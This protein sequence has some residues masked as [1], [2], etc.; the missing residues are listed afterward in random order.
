MERLI[1]FDIDGTLTRS[2]NGYIPFNEA[3]L[4]T[5]GIQG[6]IRT[7]VPDGNTDPRIVE[8]IFRKANIEMEIAQGNREQFALNLR[9]RYHQS[10]QQGTTIIRALPG[11][12]ELL[13]SLAAHGSYQQG[14]VTGNFEVTARIKLEA[15]GLSSY[16]GRG[17]FAGDSSHRPDLPAIAKARFELSLGKPIQSAQCIIVGDTPNDLEAARLNQ[18][19]CVL[20]GTGR[21]PLEE[22]LYWQP[23]ACLP[24]LSDTALVLK[25]I[26]NL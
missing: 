18:M 1:L 16:L 21:Y 10:V 12:A 26:M 4:K 19:K 7:V 9:H 25:T 3:L 6:D 20:V 17:A 14:I 24:D 23:D 5:F 22:L 11:T 8:A 15:A 2:Q 13:K